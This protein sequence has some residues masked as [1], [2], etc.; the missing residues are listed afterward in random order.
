M[1]SRGERYFY[2]NMPRF[3]E[4]VNEPLKYGVQPEDELVQTDV[5]IL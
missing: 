5:L 4:N 2:D 1:D 3:L